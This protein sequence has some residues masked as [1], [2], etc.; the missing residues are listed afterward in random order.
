MFNDNAKGIHIEN[1]L[2]F[3][4]NEKMV[5]KISK[6]QSL[7]EIIEWLTD[8]FKGTYKVDHDSDDE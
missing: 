6:N 1:K 5:L 4:V 3:T 8:V 2:L 7:D